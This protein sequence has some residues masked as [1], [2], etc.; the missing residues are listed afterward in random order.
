[1]SSKHIDLIKE[2]MIS[3]EKDYVKASNMLCNWCDEHLDNPSP[4]GLSALLTIAGL[5]RCA[6]E[7]KAFA[8]K[9]ATNHLREGILNDAIQDLNLDI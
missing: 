2:T 1:M 8:E 6:N 9:M 3:S 4:E 7:K 5:F